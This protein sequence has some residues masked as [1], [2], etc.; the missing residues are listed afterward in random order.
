MNEDEAKALRWLLGRG[1][2]TE[3]VRTVEGLRFEAHRGEAD[4]RAA[5]SRLLRGNAPINQ[6]VRN[7]LANVFEK[8]GASTMRLELHLVRRARGKPP[9]KVAQAMKEL[10]RRKLI[11]KHERPEKVSRAPADA[12]E[13]ARVSESTMQRAKRNTRR[14][15]E[16]KGPQK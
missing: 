1:D 3:T 15:R 12:A 4:G 8:V 5:L 14:A 16:L 11:D 10:D 13:E 7:A 6:D 2:Q 9:G